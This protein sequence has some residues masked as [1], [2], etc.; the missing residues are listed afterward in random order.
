M[1][2]VPEQTIR[3]TNF[4]HLST[5]QTPSGTHSFATLLWSAL[6]MRKYEYTADSS[7]SCWFVTSLDS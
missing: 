4:F 2:V 3:Q 7:D 6:C 5:L 1:R